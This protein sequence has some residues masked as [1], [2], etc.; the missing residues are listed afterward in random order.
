MKV[1]LYNKTDLTQ[2]YELGIISITDSTQMRCV[3]GGGRSGEYY[4]RVAVVGKGM[5]D[6]TATSLFKY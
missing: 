5:S 3:L 1:Y 2:K 4:L 6:T